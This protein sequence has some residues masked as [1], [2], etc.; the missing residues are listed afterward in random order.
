M[1]SS[2]EV[3]CSYGHRRKPYGIRACFSRDGCETW[4]LSNEVILRSDGLT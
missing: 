4:D 3:L 2:D 1:L